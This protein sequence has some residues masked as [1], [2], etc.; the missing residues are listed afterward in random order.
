MWKDEGAPDNVLEPNDDAHKLVQ[1]LPISSS[2][3]PY[4]LRHFK[5]QYL[6]DSGVHLTLIPPRERLDDY[7]ERWKMKY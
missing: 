6:P 4:L 7:M 5:G 2:C 1:W 3:Q